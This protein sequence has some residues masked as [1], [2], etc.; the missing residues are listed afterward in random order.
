[1]FGRVK[2]FNTNK[3]FGFI[4]GKDS[5][6]YFVHAREVDGNLRSANTGIVNLQSNDEVEF[7]PSV[8]SKGGLAL[9]VTKA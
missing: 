6:D 7:T 1:M 5:K 4:L 3:S 9:K 8:N 2:L